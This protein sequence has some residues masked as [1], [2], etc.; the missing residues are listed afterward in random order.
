MACVGCKCR[1]GLSAR[2]HIVTDVGWATNVVASGLR[3][4]LVGSGA[5]GSAGWVALLTVVH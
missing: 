1:L 4:D 5:P 2:A 3:S